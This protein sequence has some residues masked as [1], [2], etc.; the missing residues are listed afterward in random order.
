MQRVP[1][2]VAERIIAKLSDEDLFIGSSVCRVWWQ[3]VR[4]EAYKRWKEYA[5]RIGD[6]Y[7][8]I[9]AIR[10]EELKGEID[11]LDA[12]Y[13]VE[14]LINW[15][16]VFTEDQVNIMKKMLR[17]GMVVDLQE[18]EIIEHASS[19]YNWGGNPWRFDW[20][21]NEWTQQE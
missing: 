13:K 2:E 19:E 15:M 9:Q 3:V 14:S 4:Q 11:W 12:E 10:E 17:Y 5:C 20:E 18:K 6:I 1:V 21:W 8:E 7:R 16:D